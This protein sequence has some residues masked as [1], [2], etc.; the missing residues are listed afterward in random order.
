RDMATSGDW[1][2]PRVGGDLYQDKPPVFFWLLAASYS[3]I[4][5]I[6]H[7]FLLPSLLAAAGTLFLLYDLG[8]RLVSRRAGFIAALATV[9]T[10][11]F[12]LVMRGAQIDGVLCLLTTLSLYGL[13]RHLVLGPAWGWYFIGGLAAGIGIITKGVGFLPF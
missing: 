1:L 12:V 3:L 4:G 2:F 7:S 9:S 5:T 8:R 10:L 13:L 11:Q 6:R